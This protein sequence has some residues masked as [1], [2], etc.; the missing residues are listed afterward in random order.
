MDSFGLDL[1][2]GW[3]LLPPTAS[4]AAPGGG[5]ESHSHLRVHSVILGSESSL[6]KSPHPSQTS[7]S[8]GL[9][10]ALSF[11]ALRPSQVLRAAPDFSFS[12]SHFQFVSKPHWHY[13]LVFRNTRQAPAS[14]PLHL[15]F[16]LPEHSSLGHLQGPSP[17]PLSDPFLKCCSFTEAFD[18]LISGSILS[19]PD[20]PPKYHSPLFS[21]F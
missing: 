12:H 21:R 18:C 14:G 10:A 20:F 1:L 5:G 6:R 9:M 13:I 4:S 3:G 19:L 2:W 7:L 15:L 8:Q 11:Q 16:A 17:S